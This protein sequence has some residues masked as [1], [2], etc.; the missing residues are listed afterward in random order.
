MRTARTF[1][2]IGLFA[3]KHNFVTVATIF[4]K[5]AQHL[6]PWYEAF[7]YEVAKPDSR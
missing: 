4:A 2:R 7:F 6:M 3:G 1:L 5:M